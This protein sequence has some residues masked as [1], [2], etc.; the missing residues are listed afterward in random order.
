MIF[1]KGKYTDKLQKKSRA[2]TLRKS[3]SACSVLNKYMLYVSGGIINHSVDNISQK[4]YELMCEDLDLTILICPTCGE[5]GLG[6]HSYGY[7]KSI[8]TPHENV[9]YPWRLI[10]KHCNNPRALKNPEISTHAVLP[11]I[12]T[13]ALSVPIPDAISFIM[14]EIVED[15][16]DRESAQVKIVEHNESLDLEKALQVIRRYKKRWHQRLLSVCLTPDHEDICVLCLQSFHYQ[17]L[18]IRRLPASLYQFFT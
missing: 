11:I 13:E 2:K 3:N 18:Q 14:T 8:D 4:N 16:D 6:W 15:K 5:N 12:L 7:K 1:L 9:I 10:C 17:F